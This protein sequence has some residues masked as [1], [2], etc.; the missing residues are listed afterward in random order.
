MA[1]PI[2]SVADRYGQRVL[3]APFEDGTVRVMGEVWNRKEWREF[4]SQIDELF[5]IAEKGESA[6]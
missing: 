1:Y 2:W 4:K 6:K 5:T 3:A